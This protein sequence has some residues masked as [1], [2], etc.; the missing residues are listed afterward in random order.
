VAV[1]RLKPT[2]E[3]LRELFLKSGNLC[4]FPDCE[5]LMMNAKGVF[6]AQV[7]HI[8][9][10][11]EGGERFN[12]KMTN[13]ERRHFANL[14]LMCYPHHAETNDVKAFPV[15]KLKKIKADHEG[16]FS[17]PD[18]AI[19]EKLSDKTLRTTSTLPANLK[20]MDRV[21]GWDYSD[22][23][24]G[25]AARELKGY[26]SK[27]QRVPLESRKFLSEVVKRIHRMRKEAVTRGGHEILATD[28][29]AAFGL[30]TYAVA[31]RVKKLDS[32]G[33]A[34][35]GQIDNEYGDEPSIVVSSLDSGWHLWEELA[36]F[37][38][39]TKEPLEAFTIDMDF[40]RLDEEG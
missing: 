27:F 32:Y 35:I 38:T 10:A 14:M 2:G 21:L 7:C 22:E 11:E 20:R 24:L 13:E 16:R 33:L 9:A 39:K 36:K 15:A 4:A 19:L 28:I 5:Q 34:S 40:A 31:G 8:E 30:S 6:I 37:C 29:E 3:T 23:E 12:P 1:K 17:N 26:A 18:R 25:T